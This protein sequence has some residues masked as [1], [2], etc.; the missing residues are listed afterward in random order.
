MAHLKQD[1][2]QENERW[3]ALFNRQPI[4]RVALSLSCIGFA[5]RNV[6]YPLVDIYEDAEKCFWS[7]VW[8]NEMYGAMHYV[9]YVW[10]FGARE[11]GGE[12]KMPDFEYGMAPSLLR[13]AIESEEDI[14]RLE[15]EPPD[16]KTAGAV[17]FFM[18]FSKLAER[19]SFPIPVYIGGTL[20]RVGY[21]LD[22][23]RM[24]K[25][26]IKKPDLV[27]RVCRLETDFVL[28][29][30]KYWV[31]TFGPERILGWNGSP[32]ESNQIISPKKFEEFA[33]P[34]QGEVYDYARSLGVQYFYTHLCGEQ[35]LNLPYWAQLFLG[36]PGII[37]IGHE[38]D[39]ETA[40]RYFP[41]HII[42]G[43]VNTLIIQTGT[44][45]EV[46]ESARICI[47]KGKKVPGGF[48]LAPGCEIPVNAPPYNV[49]MF[50]KAINDFGWYD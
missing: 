20:S 36:D 27:H 5:A 29:K 46:Y 47:E 15:I 37:S 12:I 48:I 25:W 33:L 35:N 10:A 1:K 44:P 8:T 7:Q 43:N 50:R 38:V 21:M 49:W 17:P 23:E 16:V 6:G 22:V 26:M 30:I 32:T 41:N 24:C 40:A 18:K 3:E 4:D 28:A 45:Q 11:F 14:E 34:Y 31:N 39:I 42:Y 19:Y 9:H 13:P 2:M